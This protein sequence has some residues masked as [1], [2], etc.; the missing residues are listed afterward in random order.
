[1]KIRVMVV[2]DEPPIQ[3][4]ICQKIEEIN[5]SFQVVATAD[6]GRE[7]YRYLQEHTVD[8]LFVDMNHPV[9]NGQ[10]LLHSV[11][12]QNMKLIPVVLSG[13]T[14]FTYVKSAF[15]NNALDYLLKPL[16]DSELKLLL[17]RLEEKLQRQ[18]F[19]EKAHRFEE[20]LSGAELPQNLDRGAE[21][22]HD[23]SDLW[24]QL[25]HLPGWRMELSRD[26]P[27]AVFG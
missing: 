14:D 17:E 8:V 5:S 24:K 7:A 15:E 3:R 13:Y 12:Q 11:A 22:R 19:E 20:A 6:N 21:I 27:G 16:K 1:M 18:W 26:I 23:A 9:L 4:N 10:E 25:Q 2:E